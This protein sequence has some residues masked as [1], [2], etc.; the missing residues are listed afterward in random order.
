MVSSEYDAYANATRIVKSKPKVLDFSYQRTRWIPTKS[1]IDARGSNRH[2]HRSRVHA[3][4]SSGSFN[5]P[6]NYAKLHVSF[7]SRPFRVTLLFVDAQIPRE[8]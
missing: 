1:P 4:L 2:F 7:E 3:A 6:V 5:A 8:N